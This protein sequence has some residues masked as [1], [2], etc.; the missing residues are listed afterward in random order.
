MLLPLAA[1]PFLVPTDRDMLPSERRE[2]FVRTAP[3][4]SA[5]AAATTSRPCR[6]SIT[7]LPTPTNYWCPRWPA[8]KGRIRDGRD[9]KISLCVLDERWPFAYLSRSTPTRLSNAT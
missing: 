9:G 1:E 5:T 2:L 3:V 7:S 6:S 4:C 8:V